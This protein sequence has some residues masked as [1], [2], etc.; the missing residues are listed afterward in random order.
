MILGLKKIVCMIVIAVLTMG[1]YQPALNQQNQLENW[2]SVQ[3]DSPFTLQVNQIA[4]IESENLQLQL[5]AVK[6][7]S[8]CPNGLQCVWSG[9]VEIVIKVT[10]DDHDVEL[11]L[12]DKP[13][14]T[15]LANQTF[16]SYLIKLIKVTPYPENN[17]TI[18]LE[19]YSATLMVSLK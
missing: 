11:S 12:I 6:N 8:R 9:L 4:L 13:G 1:C 18:E 16:A 17:Q 7:D 15:D 2:V 14:D 5:V 10:R 3:F 19:D